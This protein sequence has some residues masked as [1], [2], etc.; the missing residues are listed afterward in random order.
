MKWKNKN[1]TLKSIV[2][3]VFSNTGI[4]PDSLDEEK[5][6]RINKMEKVAMLIKQA[7]QNKQKICVVADYDADGINSAAILHL[8]LDAL[9]GDFYIRIPRRMSEGYGLNPKIVDEL[10]ANCLLICVDNG[11]VAFDAIQNAKEKGMTV[12]ILDHHM[13]KED[14]TLP[15]A[16]VIIDPAAIGEADFKSYCGAGLAYKL[17]VE[18]LGKCHPVA[19]KCLSFA[20]IATVA[21]VMPLI[22]ENRRIVKTGLKT[23]MTREGRT[24]G[25]DAL[26]VLNGLE[27]F[28]NEKNHGFKIAPCLNAPGRLYDDGATKSYKLLVSDTTDEEAAELAKEV[29]TDN[30][31][32]KVKKDEGVLKLERNI[33]RN[34]LENDVPLILYEDGLEEGLIGLYAGH[35]AEILKRPCI[36]FTDST[37]DGVIKG[38]AR[39][40][41]DVHLKN[42]LDNN[43]SLL[44]KYGG[45]KGAAGLSIYKEKLNVF[46]R[47]LQSD[48]A[49]YKVIEENF[50]DLEIDA[51]DVPNVIDALEKFAPYGEGNPEIVFK[52]NNFQVSPS[53]K[54]YVQTMCNGKHGKILNKD[55]VSAV[56]FGLGE[57]LIS[58]VDEKPKTLNLYGKLAVNISKYGTVHQVEVDD[59]EVQHSTVQPTSLAEKLREAANNKF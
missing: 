1:P 57:R 22:G 51:K 36:V 8:T 29:V 33:A 19:R 49:G 4:S 16:D 37:I 9:G 24:K 11:I 41:G 31:L 53:N 25:L 48:L 32:R 52:V 30:E 28:I 15:C 3:V 6:Y 54:G 21:D 58:E 7:I 26:V 50:Y 38:S 35:F 12:V 59:F 39:S 5:E 56:A 27:V 44:Y 47:A 42:L 43:A 55:R 14:G 17:S 2:D 23:M 20:A 46:R 10:P 40:Y 45:H 18:L 34:G 13:S